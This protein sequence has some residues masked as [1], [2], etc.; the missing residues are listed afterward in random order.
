METQKPVSLAIVGPFSSGKSTLLN[1][2]VGETVQSMGVLP[3]TSMLS[4]LTWGAT[5]AGRIHMADGRIVEGTFEETRARITELEQSGGAGAVDHVEHSLPQTFLQHLHLWDTPGLNS[6]YLH[7]EIVAERAIRTADIILWVT[8]IDAAVTREEVEKIAK[9]KPPKTPLLVVINKIDVA[10]EKE[11]V[12]VVAGI[13]KD[14]DGV[15]TVVQPAAARAALD[16]AGGTV[17]EFLGDDGLADLRQSIVSFV[18]AVQEER[19]RPTTSTVKERLKPSE[20][21]CPACSQACDASDKY[22]VCGRDLADQHRACPRC[23]SDNILRR[24]RCRQCNI[25]FAVA[26]DSDA[27]ERQAIDDLANLD[28]SAAAVKLRVAVE[29]D[30]SVP[31]RCQLKAA[32]EQEAANFQDLV[33]S[34]KHLLRDGNSD[35]EVEAHRAVKVLNKEALTRSLHACAGAAHGRTEPQ[36]QRRDLYAN[37]EWRRSPNEVV[38]A[39][40]Q[41]DVATQLARAWTLVA[42]MSR[43][44]VEDAT[45]CLLGLGTSALLRKVDVQLMEAIQKACSHVEQ[46][47]YEAAVRNLEEA[48][49][50]DATLR[51]KIAAVSARAGEC[52]K[53]RSTLEGLD[54]LLRSGHLRE[55][56][57][58]AEELRTTLTCLRDGWAQDLLLGVDRLG[59][60]IADMENRAMWSSE[61]ARAAEEE[62]R[63][64][65][66]MES[67]EAACIVDRGCQARRDAEAM[68]LPSKLTIREEARSKARVAL[69]ACQVLQR[70]GR[71]QEGKQ[72]LETLR[73]QFM[74]SKACWARDVLKEIDS[75]HANVGSLTDRAKQLV[76]QAQIAVLA[77][78]YEEAIEC[79]RE[80]CCLDQ[81]HA[82]VLSEATTANPERI[83]ARDAAES[84]ALMELLHVE[85]SIEQGRLREARQALDV[86]AR[87]HRNGLFDWVKKLEAKEEQ[88][89][90]R[91]VTEATQAAERSRA[92]RRVLTRCVL[93][94]LVLTILGFAV[95]MTWNGVARQDEAKAQ[96]VVPK[97]KT[98]AIVQVDADKDRQ[99]ALEERSRQSRDGSQALHAAA[100]VAK[101]A[102]EEITL[103]EME[104]WSRQGSPELRA[105]ASGARERAEDAIRN[106][107]LA[108]AHA[109]WEEVQD[110]RREFVAATKSLREALVNEADLG[111]GQ[112]SEL[113]LM[114]S[115]LAALG[116]PPYVIDALRMR[117]AQQSDVIDVGQTPSAATEHSV[118]PSGAGARLGLE[119]EAVGGE[120][121]AD[122]LPKRIQHKA[123]GIVLV[124]I[125]AGEFT[126]GSPPSEA[127]RGDDETQ[128]RRVI[129][130]PFYIGATEVTQAQWQKVMGN[131]PSIDLGPNNPVERVSWDDCQEFLRK[132]GGGLR[133]PSEAEW[134][135]SCRAGTTGP[136]SFG[137]NITPEQVNYNSNY[138][139][140]NGGYISDDDKW[141]LE[142]LYRGHTVPAKSL[143][144]NA[145]GLYEM[146]GNVREWCQDVDGIYPGTGTEEPTGG[147]GA[148]VH[149]GGSYIIFAGYCRA[150]CRRGITGRSPYDVI[151]LRV[152]RTV[153][154]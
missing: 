46:Q 10:E 100:E 11:L 146:H 68:A 93:W 103:M 41:S 18:V 101:V 5:R 96:V 122:G 86:F 149:R 27:I 45:R 32:I 63:H 110:E 117:P 124:L 49:S 83:A 95:R 54:A 80:A 88:V 118:R 56:Q 154:Q 58:G 37:V 125:P 75:L 20:F 53:V 130:K 136:F 107:N 64:E 87:V 67:W 26:A 62:E 139:Y 43:Q 92:R 44:G 102:S 98:E 70:S 13:R 17:S 109:E 15:A 126:M 143:P 94:L 57:Q 69:E 121:A 3:E 9:R 28:L 129:G 134:E 131:N 60:A 119:F 35:W 140:A 116:E 105:L 120:W 8:P 34:A 132:G 127:A 50:E 33:V 23:A 4:H 36:R 21:E 142:R 84:V 81:R 55:A 66:A 91:L 6:T 22:C 79:L 24:D 138:P 104:R 51:A 48:A 114:L 74:F 133:L 150:A 59:Q 82:A 113:E 148:R 31:E 152:A 1:A 47:T 145:W 147:A 73:P 78:R 77:A 76:W 153:P 61:Q 71:L 144:A 72:A 89:R 97:V 2:L 123:T 85:Q 30:R 135:Y 29:M 128:H 14:L 108:I 115:S 16:K 141:R 52:S 42:S 106:C 65:D 39:T 40:I 90:S 137:A 12:E 99:S 151:G 7:H 25:V 38:R 112:A 111:R 19:A